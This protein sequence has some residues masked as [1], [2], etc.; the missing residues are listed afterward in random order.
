[1]REDIKKNAMMAQL[2][3]KQSEVAVE[4]LGMEG[5]E[6]QIEEIGQEEQV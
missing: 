5:V 3:E 6:E 2:K 4:I 1:M